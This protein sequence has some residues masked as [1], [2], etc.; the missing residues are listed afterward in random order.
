[1][2]LSLKIGQACGYS[3]DVLQEDALVRSA[4]QLSCHRGRSSFRNGVGC[5][6]GVAA[7][8]ATGKTAN[9]ARNVENKGDALDERAHLIA[10]FEGQ[11]P[12]S[13]EM[14]NSPLHTLSSTFAALWV[15]AAT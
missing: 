9:Q 8:F 10:D 11:S 4:G 14:I 3:C 5:G 15:K 6:F 7:V 1:M 13:G 12:R 2:I